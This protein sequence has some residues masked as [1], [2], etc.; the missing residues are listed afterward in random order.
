[1][2]DRNGTGGSVAALYDTLCA[3]SCTSIILASIT[4]ISRSSI[5]SVHICAF[6]SQSFPHS[7]SIFMML[8][9]VVVSILV[10]PS[11]ASGGDPGMLLSLKYYIFDRKELINSLIVCTYSSI[12][13]LTTR[14]T[15]GISLYNFWTT[16]WVFFSMFY[17]SSFS[18][19]FILSL[20]STSSLFFITSYTWPSTYL[21]CY[22]AVSYFSYNWANSSLIHSN[23]LC[24]S[25]PLFLISCT[26]LSCKSCS[27]CMGIL[28]MTIFI[29]P[30]TLICSC[31]SPT[32]NSSM[33]VTICRVM[34]PSVNCVRD[35]CTLLVSLLGLVDGSSPDL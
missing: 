20:S 7:P 35:D 34:C 2:A 28:E 26:S 24:S 32:R 10:R 8:E 6:S 13:A 33:Y 4:F 14:G 22:S 17:A 1:M 9:I 5:S 18:F 15:F 3:C 31:N 12:F 27:Y 11:L 19:T 23:S 25:S 16:G 29:W 21:F 30:N